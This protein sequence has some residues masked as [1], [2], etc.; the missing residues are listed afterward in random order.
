MEEILKLLGYERNV[1][2]PVIYVKG[3]SIHNNIYMNNSH[4]NDK[5]SSY[6]AGDSK[7]RMIGLEEAGWIGYSKA[8]IDECPYVAD[9]PIYDPY[10]YHPNYLV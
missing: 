4:P 2:E 8:L 6:K 9:Q 7:G 10:I 3:D 5:K 1:I